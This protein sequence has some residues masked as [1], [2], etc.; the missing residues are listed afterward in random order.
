MPGSV[1]GPKNARERTDVVLKKSS[2]PPAG[3]GVSAARTGLRAL[4]LLRRERDRLREEL[5]RQEA[6]I[7][8]HPTTG[9]HIADDATEVSE[10]AKWLAL[11][12][13]L[14]GM[15]EETERAILRVE[16]GTYGR[17]GRCGKAISPERLRVV[18]S[19]AF[20]IECAQLKSMI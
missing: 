16:K 9:N 17:C 4:S 5:G 18:P 10:Q 14:Q 8:D 7:Q 1:R 13:H 11:R 3:A 2:S 6:S 15:L 19:A 20:C 12:R